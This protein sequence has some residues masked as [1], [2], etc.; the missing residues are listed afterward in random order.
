MR[1]YGLYNGL[2]GLAMELPASAT[3]YRPAVVLNNEEN[4]GADPLCLVH[5]PLPSCYFVLSICRTLL[6]VLHIR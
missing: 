3:Q 6:S 5:L 2:C 1:T 4:S